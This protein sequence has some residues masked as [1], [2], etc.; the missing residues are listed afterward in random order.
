MN[1][2]RAALRVLVV[3]A[4]LAVGLGVMSPAHAYT[5]RD[6]CTIDPQAP[7]HNGTFTLGGAKWIDYDVD[8]T[9]TGGRTIELD[10]RRWEA[11]SGLNFSDDLIGTSTEVRYFGST[12]S[13]TWT[14][15]GALP[16]ND[17]GFDQYS[18]MYQQVNFRVSYNG[19]WGSW[20]SWDY[21]PVRSI[22]V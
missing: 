18:E 2:S 7:F 16:D 14:V 1:R 22:H 19:A 20:T 8:I 6:G 3:M 11:D 9:C 15:T 21:S 10:M 5:S 13:Y 12:S 4:A 17:S